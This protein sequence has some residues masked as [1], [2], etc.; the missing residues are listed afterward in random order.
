MMTLPFDEANMV[1]LM[2]DVSNGMLDNLSDPSI[3]QT[4]ED[5]YLVVMHSNLAGA[6]SDTIT[7]ATRYKALSLLWMSS[8]VAS[9]VSSDKAGRLE[10][11]YS[12]NAT[13]PWEEAYQNL[14]ASLGFG[15]WVMKL[16]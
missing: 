11:D 5:A 4:I 2:K 15:K 16:G 10:T 14:L 12:E 13:N 9:G 6:D 8:D 1:T 7:L 3:N